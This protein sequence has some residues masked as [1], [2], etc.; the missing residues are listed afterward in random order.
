ME[1]LEAQKVDAKCDELKVVSWNARTG[2]IRV[3]AKNV[4][5]AQWLR[6]AASP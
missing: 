4:N 5:K 3:G 6:Y 1:K 2:S